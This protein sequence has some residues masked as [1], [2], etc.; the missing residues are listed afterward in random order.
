MCILSFDNTYE[1]LKCN[2]FLGVQEED[3]VKFIKNIYL[4]SI[5]C[6]SLANFFM[7]VIH[8]TSPNLWVCKIN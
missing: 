3:I 8:Q 6:Y 1:N 4:N 5:V 2:W 7:E